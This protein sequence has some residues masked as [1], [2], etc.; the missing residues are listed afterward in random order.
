MSHYGLDK[1]HPGDSEHFLGVFYSSKFKMSMFEDFIVNIL[2]LSRF[3]LKLRDAT[4]S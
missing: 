3:W 2:G 4:M 1:D